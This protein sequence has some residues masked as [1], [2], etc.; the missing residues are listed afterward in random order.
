L[1]GD[2]FPGCYGALDQCSLLYAFI[3]T[4]LGSWFT[5]LAD[6][7]IFK[8]DVFNAYRYLITTSFFGAEM[9]AEGKDHFD[10]GR[11]EQ[12]AECKLSRILD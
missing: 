3:L 10:E 12:A 5:I 11:F 7:M 4:V 1:T 8:L 6:Q 2:T 9:W